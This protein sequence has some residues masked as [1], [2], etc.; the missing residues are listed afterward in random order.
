MKNPIEKRHTHIH[1]MSLSPNLHSSEN[2]PLRPGAMLSVDCPAV[3]VVHYWRCG[4]QS[5]YLYSHHNQF[6]EAC[7]GQSWVNYTNSEPPL[8]EFDPDIRHLTG[9]LS[10]QVN[11]TEGCLTLT[12]VS[13]LPTSSLHRSLHSH[14]LHFII[15]ST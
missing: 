13:V 14:Q 1:T 6:V 3:T 9:S 15:T 8:F 2:C 5:R 4:A 12:L 7:L 10:K 11:P